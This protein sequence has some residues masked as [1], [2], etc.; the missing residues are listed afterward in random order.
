MTKNQ[1]IFRTK[2]A[3][4]VPIEKTTIYDPTNIAIFQAGANGSVIK[5][6]NFLEDIVI[7]DNNSEYFSILYNDGQTDKVIFRKGFNSTIDL[8]TINLV[9]LISSTTDNE[10]KIYLQIPA[11]SS[12]ILKVTGNN[13]NIPY[14]H[15]QGEDY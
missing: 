4:Y 5:S 3:Q 11:N 15:I 7:P 6:I 9:S 14:G 1:L 13:I 10:G 8:S 12:I 2:E